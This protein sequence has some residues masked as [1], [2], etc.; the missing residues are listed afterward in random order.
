M[1]AT[2]TRAGAGRISAAAAI[3]LVL[4][5]AFAAL[6]RSSHAEALSPAGLWQT[7]WPFRAGLAI[8]WVAAL[9]WRAPTA[10]LRSGIPVWIGTVALG[11][12]LRVWFTTGGAALPFIIVA[13][14]TLGILLLGWRGIAALIRRL[15]RGA[16]NR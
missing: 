14:V 2:E 8:S 6:G 16:R 1:T 5:L 15:Q 13:T 3:D 7:A 9:V 12:V 4:V 10:P 11:M